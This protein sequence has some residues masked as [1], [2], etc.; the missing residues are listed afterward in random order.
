ML[1]YFKTVSNW[2]YKKM[3]MANLP[4]DKEVLVV[5]NN[6]RGAGGFSQPHLNKTK[7]LDKILILTA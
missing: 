4:N 2:N 7:Y 1:D 6:A 3:C 5:Q